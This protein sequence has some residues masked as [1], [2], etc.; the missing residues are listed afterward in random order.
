MRRRDDRYIGWSEPTSRRCASQD[1]TRGGIVAEHVGD[2]PTYKVI[3]GVELR[4]GVHVFIWDR[5]DYNYD[6][7]GVIAGIKDGRYKIHFGGEASDLWYDINQIMVTSEEQQSD[8]A[9]AWRAQR[10]L[11]V[12]LCHAQEDKPRVRE[13][14]AYLAAAG[15]Q[16]WLDERDIA[17]GSV[18]ED[19]IG[20]AVQKSHVVL[21]CLS[22]ASVQK[23]GYVQ[24]EIRFILDRAD[25]SYS[26]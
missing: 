21:V 25:G 5:D 15:F 2:Q 10:A 8:S 18:W 9:R 26:G 1:F 12:F 3:N 14:Y 23:T 4:P 13:L 24:K 6:W 7:E 17:P 20:I 11:K 22:R 16:P 19:A